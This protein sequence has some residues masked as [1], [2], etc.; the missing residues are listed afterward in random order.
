VVAAAGN[1]GDP[2]NY[3]CLTYNPVI[4][5]AANPNVLAVGATTW[6]DTRA[7]FSE[8]GYFVDVMAPGDDIYSTVWNDAYMDISGTSMASPLAA[9]LASLVWARQPT[10]S[11]AQ[12]ASVI[13]STAQDLGTSGRDDEYGYGRIDA[14]AAVSAASSLAVPVAVE[15][16][17][18]PAARAP[19]DAPARPGVV[20]VRWKAGALAADRQSVLSR[21]GLRMAGQIEAI[22]V[23]KVSAPVGQGREI[24]AQLAADPAV[25]F[26]EPDYRVRLV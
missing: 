17:I 11:N 13:M 25:E 18:R 26:A 1:C 9:G 5:P 6:S 21:H 15:K 20:L 4:Y 24:A 7:S 12:V 2:T 8:Y 3:S 23:F 22:G 16:A 14:A 10:L 19:T